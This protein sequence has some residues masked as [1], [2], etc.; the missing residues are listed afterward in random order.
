MPEAG[1]RRN[2]R[3]GKAYAEWNGQ[4]WVEYPVTGKKPGAMPV[5]AQ[6]LETDDLD[7]ISTSSQMNARLAPYK[8]DLES[9]KLDLGPVRNLF[10][11][12]QN[13]VGMSSPQSREYARFRADLEKMRNDSLRLNKGVQTEGDAKRAWNELFSN[14]NDEKLV[15][16][17]LNQI[18][19]YNDAAMRSKK[20]VVGQRRA[21]YGMAP[22]NYTDI[23]TPR[24]AFSAPAAA[25]T[26]RRG[27]PSPPHKMTDDEIRKALGL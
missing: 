21:Q 24:G 4:A 15:A 2:R 5:G 11:Q 12:G 18:G 22:P 23:E 8:R 1:E 14:L 9:Q 17:R 3:D 7:F 20:S 25:A 26:P 13:A 10:M 16:E 27:P 19:E 6:K